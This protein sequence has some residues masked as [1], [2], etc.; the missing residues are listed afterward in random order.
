MVP[1]RHRVEGT[2][3]AV[4]QCAACSARVSVSE[5]PYLQLDSRGRGQDLGWDSP[6]LGGDPRGS[7]STAWGSLAVTRCEE[8]AEKNHH[9][10]TQ[11]AFPLLYLSLLRFLITNRGRVAGISLHIAFSGRALSLQ[12]G[13]V[14]YGQGN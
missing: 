13:D 6:W 5:S 2:G 10:K 1:P 14:R 9:T 4:V 11:L 8:H 12:F 3:N 7:H